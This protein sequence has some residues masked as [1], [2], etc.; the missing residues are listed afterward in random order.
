M[1]ET[2]DLTEAKQC[3]D[4][5][6][7][8]LGGRS[9][10][11]LERYDRNLNELLSELR[12]ALPGV[13]VLFAFLLVAPFNQ[14]FGRVSSF[15]RGLYFATL[16]C[17]LLASIL[18]IAPTLVH[19]LQFRRG[20][21]EC[22]VRTANR[23]TIA[24]LS[25]FAVAMTGAML[26]ITHYLFGVATAVVT[27]VLVLVAFALVWFALPLH[28]RRVERERTRRAAGTPLGSDGQAIR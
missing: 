20:Q 14:R 21:K 1:S 19:R 25:V 24:G 23:L 15:E 28:Q 9:E 12:V 11:E 6:V 4:A 7:V 18:L 26:L 10:T 22:V 27:T 5:P 8:V 16:L 2:R 13:Q 3:E 17:T